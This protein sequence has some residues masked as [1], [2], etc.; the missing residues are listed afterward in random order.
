MKGSRNQSKK[1][2]ISI[3]SIKPK[4]KKSKIIKRAFIKAPINIAVRTKPSL[5]SFFQ[6]LKKVVNS[7][8]R[9]NK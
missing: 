5:Y 3:K 4:I 8:L 1:I 7:N 6:G 2:I 9:E